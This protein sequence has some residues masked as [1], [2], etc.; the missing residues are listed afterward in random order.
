MILS[1]SIIHMHLLCNNDM[2]SRICTSRP[3]LT[4]LGS[5]AP[6]RC[7]IDDHVPYSCLG[8]V[9]A[10]VAQLPQLSSNL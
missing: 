9:W 10:A 5:E 6:S 8:Q 4:I 7:K 2:L 1:Q 3:C